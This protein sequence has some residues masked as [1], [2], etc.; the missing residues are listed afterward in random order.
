MPEFSKNP[1]SSKSG[2]QSTEVAKCSGNTLSPRG[3]VS[4][5]VSSPVPLDCVKSHASV[6]RSNPHARSVHG[7]SL[8]KKS[9]ASVFFSPT[10]TTE[11]P[12][13]R[14]ETGSKNHQYVGNRSH[15]KHFGLCARVDF[16][17]S[18]LSGFS[19]SCCFLI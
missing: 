11:T 8:A 1:Q 6:S 18:T 3:K 7:V 13:K 14:T 15:L 10:S 2:T 19:L 5:R 4:R 16:L 12:S 9:G 17:V